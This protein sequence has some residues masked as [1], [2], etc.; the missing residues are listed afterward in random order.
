MGV[1]KGIT[2]TAF[3]K[4]GVYLGKKV[5]VLFHY[6]TDASFAGEIIRDDVEDPYQTIIKL[7][8]GRVVLG[9]ECHYKDTL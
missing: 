8:D 3:P 7:K 6:N 1:H 9:T 5:L 2:A 4:Q